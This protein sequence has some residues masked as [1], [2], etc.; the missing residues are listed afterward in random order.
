MQSAADRATGS[1]HLLGLPSQIAG[2]DNAAAVPCHAVVR[3][4]GGPG[5]R[6]Y[7]GKRNRGDGKRADEQQGQLSFWQRI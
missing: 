5:G 3:S 6:C 7:G 4:A 2:D 1:T